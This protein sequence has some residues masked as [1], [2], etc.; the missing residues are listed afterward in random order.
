MSTQTKD[1]DQRTK[2]SMNEQEGMSQMNGEAQ[3]Q[4][5]QGQQG[6]AGAGSRAHIQPEKFVPKF[7]T[8]ISVGIINTRNLALTMIYGEGQENASVIERV[9]IDADHAR[10]LAHILI[11]AARQ[12]AAVTQAGGATNRTSQPNS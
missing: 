11:E 12:A 5:G 8:G 3:S 7:C 6:A 9:V 1:M 4:G 2:G 10:Q